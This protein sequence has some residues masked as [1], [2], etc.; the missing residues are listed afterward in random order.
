MSLFVAIVPS[1]T[2]IEDLEGRVQAVQRSRE[3]CDLRW[4]PSDRWHVTMAFLGEQDDDADEVIAERLDGIAVGCSGPLLRIRGSGAFGR[5]VLWAGIEGANAGDATAFADLA[6]VIHSTLRR[7]GF[8]LERRPWRP[9]L[10]LARSRGGDA[11]PAAALL[12]TYSGPGWR[13]GE[14]LAVRSQGGPA[15]VHTVIHRSP[16]AQPAS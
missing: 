10:T 3:G 5:Q 2:A 7:I 4:Q 16:L 11:R 9:H 6:Q 1:A 12:E 15:P 8:P 13:V 14:L